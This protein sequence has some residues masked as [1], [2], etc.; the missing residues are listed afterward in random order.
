MRNV[1]VC[2]MFS[3]VA[4]ERKALNLVVVASSPTVGASLVRWKEWGGHAKAWRPD[5]EARPVVSL[6]FPDAVPP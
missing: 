3:C 6:Q 5:P 2:A 1:F 4:V